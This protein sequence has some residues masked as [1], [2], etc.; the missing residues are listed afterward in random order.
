M[1]KQRKNNAKSVDTKTICKNNAKTICRNGVVETEPDEAAQMPAPALEQCGDCE[2]ANKPG[3]LCEAGLCRGCCDGAS[4][5]P[6]HTQ[7]IEAAP[8]EAVAPTP[9]SDQQQHQ[10]QQRQHPTHQ[11]EPQR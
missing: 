6:S 11:H 3:D 1:Q 2:G 7:G 9:L 8:A 4:C 10:H 5:W